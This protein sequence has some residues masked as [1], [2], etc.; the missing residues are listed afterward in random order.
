[1]VA[2][3]ISIEWKEER[4]LT[5]PSEFKFA[6]E[7]TGGRAGFPLTRFQA[8]CKE[9]TPVTFKNENDPGAKER[10]SVKFDFT[11]L[12]VIETEEPY[13]FPILTFNLPYSD[14]GE[15]IWM[16]WAGSFRKLI[17]ASAYAGM[18]MPFKILEGKVQEWHYTT[19][20]LRRPLTDENGEDIMDASGKQKWGVQ[21]A[22]AWSLVSVEGFGGASAGVN[23]MDLIVD[24][25]DGKT[26]EQILQY[27]LTDMSLKSVS[28]HQAAAEGAV[29]RTLLPTLVTAGKLSQGT[30]GKYSKVG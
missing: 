21:D 14:R 28:G 23:I 1:M 15:T 25:A 30:D 20:R 8:V 13:P 11:D 19:A 10:L 16:A 9:V 2:I 7:P 26:G 24:Y 18:N 3:C 17:P 12:T 29:S 22:N 4:K 5:Q 6:M 27:V